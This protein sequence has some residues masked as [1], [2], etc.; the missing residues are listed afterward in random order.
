MSFVRAKGTLDIKETQVVVW[1]YSITIGGTG[2]S[3]FVS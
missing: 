1:Y 3:V 2:R